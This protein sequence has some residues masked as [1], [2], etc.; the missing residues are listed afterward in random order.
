MSHDESVKMALSC[1][2]SRKDDKE[3]SGKRWEMLTYT[4]CLLVAARPSSDNEASFLL[5]LINTLP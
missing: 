1:Q 3:G 5:L 4:F 2:P